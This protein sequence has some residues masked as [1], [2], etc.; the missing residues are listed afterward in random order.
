MTWTEVLSLESILAY[1]LHIHTSG[2][3]FQNVRRHRIPCHTGGCMSVRRCRCLNS[4]SGLVNHRSFH[5]DQPELLLGAHDSRGMPDQSPSPSSQGTGISRLSIVPSGFSGCFFLEHS[6]TI[7]MRKACFQGQKRRKGPT[8]YIQ[9]D[10]GHQ[11]TSQA[12]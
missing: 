2:K 6:R 9:P 12:W 5:S 10:R 8:W 11:T 3:R 4:C 7:S 1:A